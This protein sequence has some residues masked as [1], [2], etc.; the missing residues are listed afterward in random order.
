MIKNDHGYAY[1][2]IFVKHDLFLEDMEHVIKI[3]EY[4]ILK[5]S[6]YVYYGLQKE[7][8]FAGA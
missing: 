3:G 4:R 7:Q 1:K 6:G 2:N 8:Y 5:L